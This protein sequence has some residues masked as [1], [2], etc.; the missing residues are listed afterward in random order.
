MR[1]ARSWPKSRPSTVAAR[2]VLPPSDRP[3]S[4][5]KPLRSFISILLSRA[6]SP[7]FKSMIPLAPMSSWAA[8]TA[9]LA[10]SACQ[11][12]RSRA[13]SS[14]QVRSGPSSAPVS[15]PG[16]MARPDTLPDA[17]TEP[18]VAVSLGVRATRAVICSAARSGPARPC[19]SSVSAT[20]GRC[21]VPERRTET[22]APVR[23]SGARSSGARTGCRAPGRRRSRSAS[24]SSDP[25]SRSSCPLAAIRRAG[26]S[27]ARSAR[28]T[29]AA[30]R[31]VRS[32]EK[33]TPPSVRPAIRAA[34]P[35]SGAAA[36]AD[37]GSALPSIVAR[38]PSP[39]RVRPRPASTVTRPSR[40]ALRLP[41]HRVRLPSPWIA[42]STGG[43][44]GRASRRAAKPPAGSLSV[45][46]RAR[47]PSAGA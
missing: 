20:S 25:P 41:S 45:T 35:V 11:R 47:R 6:K 2:V 29:R 38:R 12:S 24:A 43:R 32:A 42:R 13:P 14:D 19:A 9:A 28:S 3:A 39:T 34:V 18:A 30:S 7:R 37:A 5:D 1:S 33:V 4:S 10:I 27:S 8:W 26:L 23:S 46:D 16:A 36:G 44:S 17:L 31:A 15:A 22:C 21:R 40:S